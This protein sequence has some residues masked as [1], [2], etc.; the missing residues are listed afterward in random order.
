MLKP[1]GHS[2]EE[3]GRRGFVKIEFFDTTLKRPSLLL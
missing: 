1:Q 2:D 3:I